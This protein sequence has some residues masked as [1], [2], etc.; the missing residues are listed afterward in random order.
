MTRRPFYST[1]V[2]W[3]SS[4]MNAKDWLDEHGEEVGLA[5]FRSLVSPGDMRRRERAL[6]YDRHMRIDDDHHVRYFVD[7]HSGIPF[8]VHSATEQ[9]FALPEEVAAL[10][11][12]ALALEDATIEGV[13]VIDRIGQMAGKEAFDPDFE[14][15][16]QDEVID[17]LIS[18]RG[19]II[20]IEE[21]APLPPYLAL[22]IERALAH[23]GPA[24][25]L[26]LAANDLLD[27]DEQIPEQELEARARAQGMLGALRVEALTGHRNAP[28][29]A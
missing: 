14:G 4:L 29:M 5:E 8:F 21:D 2:N 17:L 13:L 1:C 22:T 3:P 11:R 16:R 12:H 24:N 23:A 9:V 18:H 10:E 26:R 6:G 19:A 7:R 25:V 28:E 15:D 27:G 20:V